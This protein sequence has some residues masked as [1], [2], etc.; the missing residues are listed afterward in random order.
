MSWISGPFERGTKTSKRGFFSAETHLGGD[1]LGLD[2]L[3][4]RVGKTGGQLGVH[5]LGM[6][7]ETSTPVPRS[8]ARTASDSPTTPCLVAQ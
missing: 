8:S 4:A 5:A 7:T 2:R 3:H 1:V 6:T